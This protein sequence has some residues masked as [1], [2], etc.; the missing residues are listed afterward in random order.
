MRKKDIQQEFPK[1]L[2]SAESI[3]V[4]E[5]TAGKL[6]EDEM[7]KVQ[8]R[9][10]KLEARLRKLISAHNLVVSSYERDPMLE[11]K[12]QTLKQNIYNEIATCEIMLEPST[13]QLSDHEDDMREEIEKSL[14][15]KVTPLM[16]PMEKEFR[17]RLD[18]MERDDEVPV[19]IDP[20]TI[21]ESFI[22]CSLKDVGLYQILNC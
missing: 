18:S 11:E 13:S 15:S 12:Y 7:Q 21:S 14:D 20:K 1:R 10:I 8:L 4:L 16:D 6:T 17:E 5:G 2:A 3:Q 19:S 22:I 9:K